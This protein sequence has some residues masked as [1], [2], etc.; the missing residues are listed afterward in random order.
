MVGV[1]EKTGLLGGASE[2]VLG[3]P[4]AGGMRVVGG[5]GLRKGTGAGGLKLSG[6]A[7]TEVVSL[8]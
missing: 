1:T 4:A 3:T 6:D 8:I 5:M 7:D 2:E